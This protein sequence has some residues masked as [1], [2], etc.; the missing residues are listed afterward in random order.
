MP[1]NIQRVLWIEDKTYLELAYLVPPVLMDG[2]YDLEVAQDASEAVDYLARGKRGK[3]DL[4]VFDLDLPPG[5]WKP[6]VEFYKRYERRGQEPAMLGLELLHFLRTG[7]GRRRKFWERQDGSLKALLQILYRDYHTT[8]VAVLSIYT[9]R[10]KENL[11]R[12]LGIENDAKAQRDLLIQKEAGM[13][14]T[15]LLRL[16]RQMERFYPDRQQ[17]D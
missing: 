15:T 17:G 6:F 8:P 4:L 5:D 9:Y 1:R 13:A 10:V 14:R 7:R 2:R 12:L 11:A 16:L 3:F